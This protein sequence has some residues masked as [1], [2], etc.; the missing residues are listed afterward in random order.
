M[1]KYYLKILILKKK[2]KRKQ[3]SRVKG[4]QMESI[5][6]GCYQSKIIKAFSKSHQSRMRVEPTRLRNP[7]KVTQTFK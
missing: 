7:S 1:I 5:G 2:K 3:A 6:L 4:Y